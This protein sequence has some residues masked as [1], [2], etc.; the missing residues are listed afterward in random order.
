MKKRLLFVIPSIVGGGAERSLVTL[1]Q[2]ID[3]SRYDIDLF[4]FEQ[5]GLFFDLL[6]EN[7]RLLEYGENTQRSDCRCR[8]VL[9]HSYRN[10]IISWL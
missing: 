1:L 4:L 5:S 6:P 10:M 2:L 3:Y 8:L 9:R 7:V